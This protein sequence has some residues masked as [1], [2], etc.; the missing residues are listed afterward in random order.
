ML[1]LSIKQKE[2]LRLIEK[3]D[4]CFLTGA[5]GTGKTYVACHS[6]LEFFE[7]GKVK[8]IIITRPLVA[9]EEVGFLPGTLEEKISP[10]MDPIISILSDI[11]DRKTI[12]KMIE[13]GEIE[14]QPLAYMR[15][16]TF[17]EAFVILDEAQ[18]TTKSQISMFLT[19]F[20]KNTKG[21]LIGDLKQSDL[22][23]PKDNGLRWAKDKLTPSPLVAGVE[24]S[25]EHV[26]RS[27]LVR[28]IMKYLYA[29]E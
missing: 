12:K 24:F 5:A 13:T 15:G 27:P 26:V 28:E 10:F 2:Y 6:A 1:E 18:N 17:K 21:C 3:Y 25:D 8:Q 22:P 4:L 20:G 7:K 16:R 14:S 11:Y 9:T 29:E 19:R 23:N